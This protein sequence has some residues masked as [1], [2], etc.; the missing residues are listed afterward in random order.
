ME[1]PYSAGQSQTLTDHLTE[2]RD[3]LIR[4][5]WAILLA[6]ILC[7]LFS[8]KIFDI[9][10]APIAPYLDAGGLIFTNPMDKFIAHMKVAV[11]GGVIVSCPVWVYQAWMFVAPGLYTNEKK[12]SMMF[13]SAGS[14]LFLLGVLF[15]YF[16]VLPMAFKFLL[17]FGGTTDKAMITINEYMSFF[18]TTTLVFGA[19][20]EL[21]LVIVILGAMGL[22]DQKFLREKRRY[23][24]VGLAILSAIITPPDVLSMMMLLVPLW[25]LYELSIILVGVMSHRKSSP[26]A[27][28]SS[29][30]H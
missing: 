18:M 26:T 7:W 30:S 20:F 19:A 17:T 2:L 10:R 29:D 13:I 27:P 22:V 25:M 23:A 11:L 12:Y 14:G 21:P 24:V 4:S 15:V 28:S 16:A 3:R 1:D 5:A 9:V 6:A 8:D